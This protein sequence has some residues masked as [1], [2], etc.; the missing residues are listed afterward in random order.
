[1]QGSASPSLS[2]RSGKLFSPNASGTCSSR[3]MLIERMLT[4]LSG[5]AYDMIQVRALCEKAKEMLMEESNVPVSYIS[6]VSASNAV[7][8]S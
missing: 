5:T 8:I 7:I 2:L 4:C 3:I 6:T 1:M